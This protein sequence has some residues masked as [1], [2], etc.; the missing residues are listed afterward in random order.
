MSSE[1]EY[2]PEGAEGS[3]DAERR[4]RRRS[5]VGHNSNNATIDAIMR[6]FEEDDALKGMFR[7]DT[8]LN[9]ITVNRPVP[10]MNHKSVPSREKPVPW[11]DA[12]VTYLERYIERTYNIVKAKDKIRD[13]AVA[14]AHSDQ[15]S[16]AVDYFDGLAWDQ[17]PRL[18]SLLSRAFGADDTPLH[19]FW[20]SALLI[21]MVR[22]AR[23]PGAKVDEILVLEGQQGKKKSTAIESLFPDR[24]WYLDG[25]GDL[26]QKDTLLSM[27]GKL[28]AEL[29]ELSSMRS[30]TVE[31]VKAFLSRKVDTYRPPYGRDVDDFAR[32]CCFIG[33]TNDKEY[34]SDTTGNRR[35]EPVTIG[36][37]DIQ[38]IKDNREQLWAEA[39]AREKAGEKHWIDDSDVELKRAAEAA[40]ARRVLT[41]VWDER[42]EDYCRGREWVSIEDFMVA[43]QGLNMDP[44]H[45][46]YKEKTRISGILKRLGYKMAQKKVGEGKRK[47]NRRVWVP[48][49]DDAKRLAAEAISDEERDDLSPI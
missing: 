10:G 14:M 12:M 38:W 2:D 4:Q 34:L 1:F 28:C 20:S 27:R 15:H 22:R 41:D 5:G 6:I 17:K 32:Q 47:K 48:D 44:K 7:L 39:S 45:Q 40:Q 37:I 9:S 46:S 29:S 24:T 18:D 3:D 13:A 23:N 43:T 11:K 35:F 21:A 31:L 33:T 8:F 19:R 25:L 30:S 16:S 42:L 36:K 26:R 49:S